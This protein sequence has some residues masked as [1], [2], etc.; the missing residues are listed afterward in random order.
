MKILR[1]IFGVISSLIAL[2]G[3]VAMIAGSI[4]YGINSVELPEFLLML[5]GITFTIL[6]I[7]TLFK[8]RKWQGII[9]MSLSLISAL[10]ILIDYFVE[11]DDYGLRFLMLLIPFLIYGIFLML[12]KPKTQ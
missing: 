8:P 12:S 2:L 10:F 6:I 3:A 1:Y 11:G 4:K 7:I 5:V 9:L